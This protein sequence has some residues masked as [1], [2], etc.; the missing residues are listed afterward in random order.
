MIPIKEEVIILN[1][2][3]KK[4]KVSADIAPK[5]KSKKEIFNNKTSFTLNL[6]AQPLDLFLYIL[7]QNKFALLSVDSSQRIDFVR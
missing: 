1:F 5:I 7:A 6:D 2:L 4:F 3:E